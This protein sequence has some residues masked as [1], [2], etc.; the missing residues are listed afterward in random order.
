MKLKIAIEVL[1]RDLHDPGSADPEVL[2]KAKALSIE[3]MKAVQEIRNYP[4]PDGIVQLP[5]ETEE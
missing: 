2:N 4:F 1:I 5:G 3:A